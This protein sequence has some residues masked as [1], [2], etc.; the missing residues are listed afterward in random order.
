MEREKPHQRRFEIESHPHGG[1][2]PPTCT[3]K[4]S[5][6]PSEREITEEEGRLALPLLVGKIDPLERILSFSCMDIEWIA[7]RYR[8]RPLGL[9]LER[10]GKFDQVSSPFPWNSIRNENFN[11][12]LTNSFLS[13]LKE[14]SNVSWLTSKRNDDANQRTKAKQGEVRSALDDMNVLRPCLICYEQWEE[15]DEAVVLPCGHLF[16]RNCAE[17]WHQKGKY[18]QCGFCRRDAGRPRDWTPI[19][20]LFDKVEETSKQEEENDAP[21]KRSGR[22]TTCV[23]TAPTERLQPCEQEDSVVGS[24]QNGEEVTNEFLSL[25]KELEWIIT[26]DTIRER[27]L[28]I[29]MIGDSF[30]MKANAR[31]CNVLCTLLQ[32]QRHRVEALGHECKRYR[33]IQNEMASL[34]T[35]L[36]NAKLEQETLRNEKREL[37]QVNVGYKQARTME[38]G[39]AASLEEKVQKLMRRNEVLEGKIEYCQLLEDP[40]ATEKEMIEQQKKVDPETSIVAQIRQ[41]AHL[42]SSI[43]T[44]DEKLKSTI[45]ELNAAKAKLAEGK[46]KASRA[47]DELKQRIEELE[48]ATARGSGELTREGQPDVHAGKSIPGTSC[49][50]GVGPSTPV[51]LL[52]D[53]E[54]SYHSDPD[55]SPLN[56]ARIGSGAPSRPTFLNPDGPVIEDGHYIRTGPD[57]K[58]GRKKVLS[59]TLVDLS[60]ANG[61]NSRPAKQPRWQEK[62]GDKRRGQNPSN[63]LGILHFLNRK[64]AYT[65]RTH[66]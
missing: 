26:N 3:S 20:L 13:F 34:K 25:P 27:E 66:S 41:I 44:A 23:A 43:R 62:L 8:S 61:N 24:G 45:K 63:G 33:N 51:V 49:C 58:G 11:R 55:T 54:E 32:R 2:T 10:G 30:W 17:T 37:Q 59:S 47:Q 5:R 7:Q 6:L 15:G 64:D 53:D 56:H 35:E 19:R 12:N 36:Q 22:T 57:G 48:K 28:D 16:H 50:P 21:W 29:Q 4:G 42:K 60:R 38:R 65:S 31:T 40:S 9:G 14:I 39:R 52:S 46:R 18:K 1:A